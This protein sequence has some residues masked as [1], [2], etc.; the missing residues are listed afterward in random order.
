MNKFDGRKS[1]S[2]NHHSGNGNPLETCPD[3]G[4]RTRNPR[5]PLCP[6]CNRKFNEKQEDLLTRAL[7]GEGVKVPDRLEYALERARKMLVQKGEDAKKAQAEK[8]ALIN[9]LLDKAR[10]KVKT[11]LKKQGVFDVDPKV[12]GKRVWEQL[13]QLLQ[14]RGE[15][16]AA[17]EADRRAFASGKAAENL[18]KFVKGAE[19]ELKARKE[20]MKNGEESPLVD[21]GPQEP[22]GPGKQAQG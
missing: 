18:E 19:L 12:Y 20:S 1:G 16:V 8:D 4:N 3:C 17:D 22:E 15:K 5:N 6:V 7:N 2:A 13:T 11:V 9:P 14:D 21:E 10:A